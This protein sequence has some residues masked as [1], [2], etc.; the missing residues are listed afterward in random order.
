MVEKDC[1]KDWFESAGGLKS[2]RSVMI[3]LAEVSRQEVEEKP[4]R[5]VFH[6]ATHL[7]SRWSFPS[8]SHSRL[9]LASTN[10]R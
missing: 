8:V 1:V 6:V 4:D 9:N 7:L 10:F 3:E 5:R 2:F